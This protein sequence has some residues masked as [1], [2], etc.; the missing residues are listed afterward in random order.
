MARFVLSALLSWRLTPAGVSRPA[1]TS[2]RDWG[3]YLDYLL[4]KVYAWQTTDGR[5]P[6][7]GICDGEF[8]FM[9]GMLNTSLIKVYEQYRADPAIKSAVQKAG[10]Y[11]MNTQWRSD[12]QQFQ[13][14]NVVCT[15]GSPDPA[16]DLNGLLVDTFGWLY[17]QSGNSAYRTV[18]DQ[19]FAN[20]TQTS[21][22]WGAKQFNQQ[23]TDSFRYLSYR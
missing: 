5:Y 12:V 8:N 20:A 15:S 14:A 23:Y 7:L 21:Y 13:Y 18:A 1:G 3:T 22:L 19:A 11:M 6:S 10:D 2:A 4:T 9:V 17:Q 16:P